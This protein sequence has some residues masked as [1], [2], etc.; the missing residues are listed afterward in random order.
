MF[1]VLLL[2]KKNPCILQIH[3]HSCLQNKKAVWNMQICPVIYYVW[4]RLQWLFITGTIILFIN[5]SALQIVRAFSHMTRFQVNQNVKYLSNQIT[6]CK[7]SNS[8]ILSSSFP[9]QK[10]FHGQLVYC[11][12]FNLFIWSGWGG[13]KLPLYLGNLYSNIGK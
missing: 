13:G 9:V 8:D 3:Y 5:C 2:G 12:N 6:V 7:F 11:L 10:C 4:I 1:F